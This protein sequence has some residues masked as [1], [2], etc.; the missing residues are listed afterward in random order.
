ME[1]VTI[2]IYYKWAALPPSLFWQK[3]YLDPCTDTNIREFLN[4]LVR[5][6]RLGRKVSSAADVVDSEVTGTLVVW[7]TR[8]ERELSNQIKCWGGRERRRQKACWSGQHNNVLDRCTSTLTILVWPIQEYNHLFVWYLNPGLPWELRQN[9]AATSHI[10]F[11]HSMAFNFTF[12][13][14][15]N[16]TLVSISP[17]FLSLVTWSGAQDAAEA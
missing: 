8:H 10:P 14:T 12:P 3:A 9:M 13:P 7:I 6:F 11:F 1:P 2:S 17:P 16:V 4:R 5:H 15:P